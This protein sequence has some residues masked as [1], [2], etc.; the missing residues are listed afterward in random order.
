MES[1]QLVYQAAAAVNVVVTAKPAKLL[2]IIVGADVGSAVIE[3]SDHASDGD[4]D[5]KI[6]L[7]G[8]TLSGVYD[9]NANFT[10]G[11][12]ADITN[13]TNLTFVYKNLGM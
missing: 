13:Q 3:I 7:A 9:I 1:G 5:V 12:S 8:D 4:G 10:K 11:I 6:Y 2:R